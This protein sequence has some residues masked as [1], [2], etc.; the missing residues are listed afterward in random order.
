MLN[1]DNNLEDFILAKFDRVLRND[2]SDNREYLHNL[3]NVAWAI[4][5][6]MPCLGTSLVNWLTPKFEVQISGHSQKIPFTNWLFEY[7]DRKEW[8]DYSTR[9][10]ISYIID[11]VRYYGFRV[12]TTAR[13][14]PASPSD[15]L[16][17]DNPSNPA[18]AT[19]LKNWLTLV[20]PLLSGIA[21]GKNLYNPTIIHKNKMTKLINNYYELMGSSYNL[22][23]H[24]L[25]NLLG[26]SNEYAL[27]IPTAMV[28]DQITS[29]F[30]LVFGIWQKGN[31]QYFNDIAYRTSE[32]YGYKTT[33]HDIDFNNP[34]DILQHWMKWSLFDAAQYSHIIIR[35]GREHYSFFYSATTYYN[36]TIKRHFLDENSLRNNV[37]VFTQIYPPIPPTGSNY[38]I[39]YVL[40]TYRTVVYNNDEKHS[41]ESALQG[42]EAN[43]PDSPIASV[44]AP[45]M[46]ELFSTNTFVNYYRRTEN[47]DVIYQMQ[48]IP[49]I[50]EQLSS[51]GLGRFKPANQNQWNNFLQNYGNQEVS[52]NG[53]RYTVRTLDTTIRNW[54]AMCYYDWFL[55][56]KTKQTHATPSVLDGIIGVE[57]L[58]LS[59]PAYIDANEKAAI[60]YLADNMP[61][62]YVVK[63]PYMKK[64]FMQQC[65]VI[66][67]IFP[68][69][70]QKEYDVLMTGMHA[71]YNHMGP[72]FSLQKFIQRLFITEQGQT[73]ANW[74]RW[75]MIT[76]P[77][78]ASGIR[79]PSYIAK[80]IQT[81]FGYAQATTTSQIELLHVDYEWRAGN[82]Q[83][84]TYRFGNWNGMTFF[85]ENY[86]NSLDRNGKI[87]R[88][89]QAWMPAFQ[90]PEFENY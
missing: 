11:K 52:Y 67:H 32:K 22:P 54:V 26:R 58:D 77:R 71:A 45:V 69:L 16:F 49:E 87:Y 25:G 38:D 8:Y 29:I 60:A 76:P 5:K 10:S 78:Y 84:F 85:W 17:Y 51:L 15:P 46:R 35:A 75:G 56:L 55:A 47:W 12:T 30:D 13:Q 33:A 63:Y 70:T 20:Q 43:H 50:F 1:F 44:S 64:L 31:A 68:I 23:E 89:W 21:T 73:I 28:M 57:F 53:R 37:K 90:H 3:F 42:L 74:E 18:A 4:E 61:M 2:F 83:R 79:D 27:H 24:V 82:G 88:Q 34:D 66:G 41:I 39:P 7:V 62:I 6:T 86:V 80:M 72:D 65:D 59:L 40:G 19:A 14:S 48:R 9:E 81:A 36:P